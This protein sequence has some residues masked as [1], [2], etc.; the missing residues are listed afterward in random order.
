MLGSPALALG[1]LARIVDGQP[2][3][4]PPGRGEVVTTGTLTDAR[5]VKPG[6]RWTSSYDALG[7]DGLSVVFT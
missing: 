7:I 5:P 2:Q 6:E 1:H 4:A 3:L